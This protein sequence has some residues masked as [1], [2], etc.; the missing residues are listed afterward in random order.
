MALKPLTSDVSA[1]IKDRINNAKS[2]PAID[3]IWDWGNEDDSSAVPKAATSRNNSE[4][5]VDVVAEPAEDED[6]PEDYPDYY[7]SE[8]NEYL[9]Q[10]E[11]VNILKK[12]EDTRGRLA[13]IYILATFMM[14]VL[15]FVVAVLDAVWRNVSIAETLGAILPLI[16]GIFLGTLGFVLGYYFRQAEDEDRRR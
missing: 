15:G 14:F 7:P 12:R 8:V 1:T 3:A 16:S 6:F 11:A 9:V 2:D 10:Q 5:D 4:F 13:I